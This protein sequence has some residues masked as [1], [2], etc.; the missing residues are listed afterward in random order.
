VP[1][2]TPALRFWR[3]SNG[4]LHSFERNQAAA[5]LSATTLPPGIDLDQD[6]VIESLQLAEGRL[7]IAQAA[8]PAWRS[9]EGWE[10]IQAIQADLNRDAAPEAALLVWRPFQSW[11]VDRYLPH[12]RRISTFHDSAG[13]SCPVFLIGWKE[14]AFRELWAGSALAD[15]LRALAAADLDGDGTQELTA[16]EA[17]YDDP[18]QAPARALTAWVWNGF[19][20]TLLDR[21][22]GSFQGWGCSQVRMD[23]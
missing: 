5:S 11:R 7:E 10:V 23:R 17:A 1:S 14:G 16:L 4:G 3:F 6:G 21:V 15:P 18:P 9:P 19:G 20:F 2:P 12:P 8:L 13:R 22:E